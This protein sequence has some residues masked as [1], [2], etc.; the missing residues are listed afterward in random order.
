MYNVFMVA[1]PT[2]SNLEEKL[3]E[4]IINNSTDYDTYVCILSEI[5][6]NNVPEE[7]TECLKN[8]FDLKEAT[9][10]V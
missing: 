7:L 3:H 1:Y 8:G 9:E 6:M 2:D 4:F 5:E 10:N